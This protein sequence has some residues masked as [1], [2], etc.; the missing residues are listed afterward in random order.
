MPEN[1]YLSEFTIKIAGSNVSTDFMKA[2]RLAEVQQS[3]HLPGMFMFELS[4]PDFTWVDNQ[5]LLKIGAEVEVSAKAVGANH[6]STPPVVLLK[7][8]ITALEPVF[9][10]SGVNYFVV[11]GYDKLHRL[12]RGVKTRTFLQTTDSDI[13]ST[14]AGEVGLSADVQS[15]SVVHPFVLQ[16]N[17]TNFE[18]I[19]DRARRNG[20]VVYSQDGKLKCRSAR[21]PAPAT[22][23]LEYGTTLLSFRPRLTWAGQAGTVVVRGWDD[24]QKTAVSAQAQPTAWPNATGVTG[25]PDSPF[26]A[27]QLVVQATVNTSAEATAVANAV[28]AEIEEGKL[29]AEG[30]AIGLGTIKPGVSVHLTKLGARFSGKYLVTNTRHVLEDSGRFV[31]EFSITGYSPDTALDLILGGHAGGRGRENVTPRHYGVVIAIVTNVNDPDGLGRVKVKYPWMGDSPAIESDWA[32]LVSPMAGSGRGFQN[33]PEVN[34][35]VVVAFEEGDIHMPF[36]IGALW[37]NSD[38][39]PLTTSNFH[40]QGKVIQRV[41][42]SRIG[43]TILLDDSDGSPMIKIID[44]TAKNWVIIDS[45]TNN[46]E[47]QAEADVTITAKGNIKATATGNIEAKATG[48]VKVEATGNLEAKATG[49]G[50]VESTGPMTVKSAANLT[51]EGAMVEIKGSAMVKIQGAL[52]Q[53]N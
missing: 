37:N 24:K 14:L 13:F 9:T 18:F 27:A 53:I 48:N 42:K 32:R 29:Q 16:D 43:H 21:T 3:L 11:R 40:N 39:P 8:E 38:K 36:V 35:E 28:K 49:T 7:G 25:A 2:L 50:K 22:V 26:G 47:V 33:M 4:D 44:K 46:V 52:V 30:V 15:T 45:K 10:E 34:D 31:T 23:A 12:H 19:W 20:Y 1:N 17:Q 51:L 6:S 5:T 41:W